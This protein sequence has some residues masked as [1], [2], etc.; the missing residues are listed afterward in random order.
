MIK[1]K[2]EKMTVIV[3]ANL[4]IEN[5]RIGF[6]NFDG[7]EGPYNVKG[8]RNFVVFLDTPTAEDL[9]QDGWNIRWLTPR[10]QDEL[11]QAYLPVAV[12]YK[13]IPPEIVVITS[14]GKNNLK[15]ENVSMLDW[16]EIEIVD[17]TI[18]PYNWEVTGK[19]GVK[20]YLKKMFV[21]IVEDPFEAKYRDLPS[22]VVP[23][24]DEED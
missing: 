2:G 21:T 11:P 18:R 1:R 14:L 13:N 23:F 19:T 24:D 7:K 6:R 4:S 15:E 3:K 9:K 12:S 22:S 20:A 16:A 17:L 10:N 5:A 8:R